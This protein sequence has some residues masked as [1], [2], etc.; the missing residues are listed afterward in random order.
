M[1]KY[2]FHASY[3]SAGAKGLRKGGGGSQRRAAVKELIEKA[4]GKLE[5]F[6]FAFGEADVFIVAEL[7]D[8]ATAAAISMTV[9]E[10]GGATL[11][12][13]VLLTAEELD[14][15]AQKTITYRPPGS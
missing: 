11:R 3:T 9:N 1:P 6:Y 13:T 12:T 15:A 8:H 10:A 7:P 5:A 4:G 2:L 14:A